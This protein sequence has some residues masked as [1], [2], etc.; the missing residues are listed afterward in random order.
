MNNKPTYTDFVI[1][2]IKKIPNGEPIYIDE[3]ANTLVDFYGIEKKKASAATSVAMK[4]IIDGNKIK[5]LRI[6]KKGVYYVANE[7][8]FGET[9]IDKEKLIFNKYLQNYE[10]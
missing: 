2:E 8:P 10:G 3:I 1:Q 9:G 5:G 6:F 4:R 7:T